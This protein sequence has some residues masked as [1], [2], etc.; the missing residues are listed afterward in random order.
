MYEE[1]NTI[2]H[3]NP[4][5]ALVVPPVQARYVRDPA[6]LLH[7]SFSVA[8]SFIRDCQID[9]NRLFAIYAPIR[10]PDDEDYQILRHSTMTLSMLSHFLFQTSLNILIPISCGLR[11]MKDAVM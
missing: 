10:N 1:F 7:I 9:F 3:T 2:L 4:Y 5:V 6:S 11:V 8:S